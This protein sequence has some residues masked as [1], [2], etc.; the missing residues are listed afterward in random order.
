M[1]S[2][3]A[4]NK[5]Q[6]KNL[7]HSGVRLISLSFSHNW[8]LILIC[9][10]V[11]IKKKPQKNLLCATTVAITATFCGTPCTT[12]SPL[13]ERER[14]A[15]G[16]EPPCPALRGERQPAPVFQQGSPGSAGSAETQRLQLRRARSGRAAARR[17]LSVR[18]TRGRPRRTPGR[19]WGPARPEP[20]APPRQARSPCGGAPEPHRPRSLRIP[21]SPPP[22]SRPLPPARLARGP[23]RLPRAVRHGRPSPPHP[24]RAPLAS[25]PRDAPR[26]RHVTAG[27]GP[28]RQR[29]AA[30]GR[31]GNSGLGTLV[32]D[33]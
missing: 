11:T 5:Q 21:S 18:R 2:A 16:S 20:R 14:R 30:P 12:P 29:A 27:A 15:A 32:W 22:R 4:K 23:A 10:S 31:D 3:Q 9:S 8:L 17:G 26:P 1:K 24:A 25:P 6:K 33:Y 13:A 28:A 19:G 7:E